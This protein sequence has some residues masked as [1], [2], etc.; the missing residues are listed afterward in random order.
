ASASS[1]RRLTACR[2]YS[3]PSASRAGPLGL[4]NTMAS[5]RAAWQIAQVGSWSTAQRHSVSESRHTP[6][7][8]REQSGVWRDSE[9][10]WRWAVDQ[11][12]TCAICHAALAEAIVFD[13]PSGPARLA[14]GEEYVRQAVSLRPELALAHYKLGTIQMARGR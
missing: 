9:T 11:E 6:L 13:S 12:P 7:C 3:S 5:A 14:E 2:T 1:G 4:S 8:T 10:L